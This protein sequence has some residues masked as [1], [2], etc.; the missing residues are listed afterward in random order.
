MAWSKENEI[1]WQQTV[2]KS[3]VRKAYVI[4]EKLDAARDPS[5]LAA[6]IHTLKAYRDAIEFLSP[7]PTAPLNRLNRGIMSLER[8]LEVIRGS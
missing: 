1:P 6:G 7:T 4:L 2:I 5:S 8:K 3:T